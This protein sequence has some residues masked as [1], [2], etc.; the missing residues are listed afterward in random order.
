[1]FGDPENIHGSMCGVVLLVLYL[2]FDSFTSQWQT[3]MFQ[4][5]KSL[6]PLQM[7]LIMNAF[8]A[9]FSLVTLLHQEEF[10]PAFVF[11]FKHPLM[12]FHLILFCVFATI[13]QLFIFYT[14]KHFGAVVFSII[15]S[16]R[17][18]FSTLL[19]CLIYSHPINEL[20][21]LGTLSS[22]MTVAYFDDCTG[23]IIVFGAMG[24]RIKKK[25]EG[26]NLLR[27][28]ENEHAKQI[29][30]EWHEHLDI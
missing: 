20:G 5:N 22:T 3:R 30:H 7:M 13:G 10:I 9:V 4:L 26:G 19:S 21:F 14:V 24:Y 17:I 12:L 23:M 6:S 15:M 11:M 18:L 16:M 29:F 25:T 27:W 8:S 1:M 2:F 28:K